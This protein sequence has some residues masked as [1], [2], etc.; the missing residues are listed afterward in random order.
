MKCNRCGNVNTAGAVRCQSCGNALFGTD[1]SRSNS[2]VTSQDQSALPPWLE[3]LRVGERSPRPVSNAPK[4][5]PTDLIEENSLPSWMHVQRNETQNVTGANLPV[6]LRSSAVPA[7]STGHTPLPVSSF[8]AQ[9]LVDEQS[10]PS[11]MQEGQASTLSSVEDSMTEENQVWM[12]EGRAAT[13][14]PMRASG[15]AAR[16]LVDQQSLPTWLTQLGQQD[17][18]PSAS[19]DQL[20][21][22]PAGNERPQPIQ[23]GQKGFA[24]RDLID[25]QSLPAWMVQQDNQTLTTTKSEQ[26]KQ[27]SSQP[28]IGLSASSLLDMNALPAWL[29]QN[30][31]AQAA[32][33][34]QP[35]NSTVSSNQSWPSQQP[36]GTDGRLA[37]SSVI[38]MNA[39]P[40]WLRSAAGTQS[41]PEAAAQAYAAPYTKPPYV[42]NVRVPS[43]PRGEIT[44]S[45]TSEMA[46]S[47]F[48]SMLGVASTAP[49]FPSPPTSVPPQQWSGQPSQIEQMTLS[50]VAGLASMPMGASM[51]G[52]GNRGGA[53]MAGVPGGSGVHS[54]V[55]MAGMPNDQS[56]AGT[57]GR[58]DMYNM[59]GG[60][61]AQSMTGVPGVSG[62]YGMAGVPNDQ[63]MA[64]TPGVPGMYS[65][66]G[67]PN[68]Q[69]M[70]GNVYRNPTGALTGPTGEDKSTKKRG[71]FGALLDWL[72]R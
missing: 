61:N 51:A 25:Q 55:G 7:P 9:S 13:S 47:V 54:M 6:S 42:E 44:S 16:D 5:S 41:A 17:S 31:Q 49:S 45:E 50:G 43:R 62:V 29:T 67:V 37:A 19:R 15:F 36:S 10:L 60:L 58:S 14:L 68:A 65:M 18:T 34:S 8:A 23:P 1:T 27:S 63:S 24:A 38:D 71:L 46:A 12:Q 4:F 72:S 69:S 48:A 57:P 53:S 11:W 22:P 70:A 3:S 64:G 35:P 2:N 30:G 33:P 66:A 20:M 32:L 40:E 56:M 39:L 59:A 52:V 26:A 28:G 21:Q